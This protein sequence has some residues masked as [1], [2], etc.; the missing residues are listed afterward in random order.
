[1]ALEI[2]PMGRSASGASFVLSIV[3][4]KTTHMGHSIFECEV[5]I[6]T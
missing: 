6:G 4:I 1:M 3:A 5:L 2:P